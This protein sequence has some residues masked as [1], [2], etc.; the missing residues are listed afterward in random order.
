MATN[1]AASFSTPTADGTAGPF[2]IGFNYLE[3][4]EIDVT[5]DG[6][7]KTL[8][9]HYTFHSATQISFTS[10]NFPTS[11]Q[12]IRFQ[13]DT[14][15]SAK[16]VDFEDG[17]VLTEA[18]LDANSDQVLFG[19]QEFTDEINTNVVKKDG[20][21]AQ[22]TDAA[23]LAALTQPEVQIL[24]GA[25]VSTTELNTLDGV[26]STL[27]ASELNVLDGITASTA[28]LNQLTNKEVETSVTTNSN[29]KIP[30]SKAVNDLVVSVANALGGFV[31]IANATSFP[32]TNPDPSNNAG[33]VVSITDA[34]GL[35]IN[36]SGVATIANGAG[37]ST[38]TINGFPTDLR[39]K[40]LSNGIGLQVQTTTTLH[41]YTYH[42]SLVK[43]SD[44]IN[45][46]DDIN[47]FNNRYRV[48]ETT[49]TSNNDEG[50]LIFR[51]SDNKLLVFNGTIF[52]EASSIGNFHT[53]TL[54]SF[55]GTGGGSATF[56]G[57]AFK[58]NIDHP[59]E[60]AE[61]LLISINNVVQKPNSGTSQPSNG[62][63]LDGSTIILSAAP[64]A[65][66]DF[67][68]VTIGKS[69]N[70]GNVSDGTITNAKVASD[71]SIEGTKINPNFGN[72]NIFTSGNMNCSGGQFTISGSTP[73]MV[74]N[75]SEDNPDYRLVNS[76]G[77]FRIRDNTAGVNRITVHTDGHI[78]IT[79]R[80]DCLDALN[81]TGD[82]SVSGTV[83]GRDLASDGSKLDGIEANAINASNTAITNKLPLSGGT[84]TGIL[85][86]NRIAPLIKFNESDTSKLY[87][88]VLDGSALSIRKD[89]LAGSNIIQ[90]WNS[91]G[92]I[93]FLTN[94]DFASGIDVSGGDITGV[95]GSSVTGTTQ[96]AN[97]NS[98]KIAT[99][100]YVDNASAS[101]QELIRTSDSAV[102]VTAD[103]IV[104]VKIANQ[105][106]FHNG[107]F[108]TKYGQIGGNAQGI[109]IL[110]S[111][112][113][114]QLK[115]QTKGAT[116][117]SELTKIAIDD[118]VTI[119]DD[120]G[121]G[122]NPSISAKFIRDGAV[123]LHY[124]GSTTPKLATT[125]TGINV[126][127]DAT[128]TTGFAAGTTS[129][130]TAVRF[131]AF[132]DNTH[133]G[134]QI[135][136]EQD[137]EGDAVLGWT[138]T[139][140]RAWSAGIDNSDSNRWKLSSGSSVD[141]NTQI[142]IEQDGFVGLHHDSASTPKLQTTAT[143][144]TVDGR[145]GVGTDSASFP[146]HIFN[147]DTGTNNQVRIEQDGTGD[148]VLG[149]ALTGVRA[150]SLGID[151]TDSDKFKIS[152]A[153]N[154]HTN[155][156][157][158]IDGANQRV[159]IN[160]TSPNSAIDV[161]GMMRSYAASGGQ[162]TS[163][164]RFATPTETFD[165]F[166]GDGNANSQFNL[167]YGGSGGA[168]IVVTHDGIVK[169][170]NGGG[171]TPKLETSASGVKVN[172]NIGIGTATP[173]RSLHIVSN[174]T[175]KIALTDS[176]TTAEQNSLV[177]GIDFT[178]LD[179]STTTGTSA[180]IGAYHEDDQGNAY[181]RFDTGNASNVTE[182]MRITATGQVD[183]TESI[184]LPNSKRLYVGTNNDLEIYYD[185]VARVQADSRPM[186]LKGLDGSATQ[187]G[188]TMFKGGSAE[189]MFEAFN[190]GAVKL[191][192]DGGT[193]SNAKLKTT[194]YG[195]TVND[196][197]SGFTGTY[198]ARVAAVIEGSNSAG[199]VLNIMSPTSGYSG[200]F[201]GRPGSAT[202]GQIHYQ[203]NAITGVPADT[204]RFITVGGTETMLMNSTSID[205]KRTV[206][207]TSS[208][209]INI[210]TAGYAFLNFETDRTDT[211]Q[212]IGGPIFLANGSTKS[213]IQSLVSG[214]INIIAGAG[215]TKMLS[216]VPQGAVNL[217]YDA[218]TYSTAK[219]STT[220]TGVDVNG[221]LEI[222]SAGGLSTSPSLYVN[223]SS[224]RSFIHTF[225][226]LTPNMIGTQ[227]NILVLGRARSTKNA[228]F[229]AYKYSGT[230]GSNDNLFTISHWGADDLLT[231]N[232][233]G[234]TT[235]TG[236]L[237]VDTDTLFVDSTNDKVGI[238]NASPAS[239][240]DITG[241]VV[242][243]GDGT[244]DDIRI[245]EW[246]AATAFAG[247]FHKN[248]TGQEY[249]MISNDGS[250][251]I[252]STT[253]N[254]VYIRGG[255]NSTTN[256]IQ[257]SPAG[258]I[259]ITAANNVNI[260]DGNIDFGSNADNNPVISMKGDNNRVK[261]RVF[262]NTDF[263][264]GFS[265]NITHGGL[266]G[267]CMTFQVSDTANRGWLFLD[268]GHGLNQGAMA[269]TSEGKM[270]VAHSLRLGYG[271]SDTTESGATHALD[272]NGS[273]I[274]QSGN[275]IFATA[276]HGAD[277]LNGSVGT[278]GI[279]ELA[280]G[281]NDAANNLALV[282]FKY[283]GT[284]G[285]TSNKVFL[286]LDGNRE[287]ITATSLSITLARNTTVNGTLTETSDIA[288]KEN[289]QP[290]S[291]VL[292]KVKQL[293]GY[294]YN[295]K[296][297][298][299]ASMGVIAQDVEKV[300]PELVHGEEGK[301]SLQYS[302][303]VGALVEAVKELS[304]KVAALE[305][306]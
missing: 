54:S 183:F 129:L 209:G 247:V 188:I 51:K 163:G 181:L 280:I 266:N 110:N 155:T 50:D 271:E 55:N 202:R 58:F 77:Q 223:N 10:G 125:S 208:N 73:A 82:I 193:Y 105:A 114:T 304:A 109:A 113:G 53:N 84:L 224:S 275:K 116:G 220:A 5:V 159:G 249:M 211:T 141:S 88:L 11:G 228:A 40:T 152:S 234:N 197:D 106:S 300:F 30:T 230:A 153:T 302:G 48:V 285:S 46:S 185:G 178:T 21:L 191:Y 273:L 252:S 26:N 65:G 250:T 95:L 89:T 200:I 3:Q 71:A 35:V 286:G 75:D 298:E 131:H 18:D 239:A 119:F 142:T 102:R 124:G 164:L 154:L 171:T 150:Y 254:H 83:D 175:S 222:A 107:T 37:S 235:I 140:T 43:E 198:N 165:M 190:D 143:G 161:T 52:Q 151:N 24:D 136:I 282:G 219:L 229:L 169:L 210:D 174:G 245:G 284:S 238:N 231:I 218:G 170:F 120:G 296:D 12:T 173:N 39:S 291:N 57:S 74:F 233:Q 167:T 267:F 31:A 236:N 134:H 85:E 290:L 221:E 80:L 70:I 288:L 62:F 126:T 44:L 281:R 60:L 246:S 293:T 289:I 123:N 42:K 64:A 237:A 8:G 63:A 90:K 2:N 66:T 301:K 272:V 14:N 168:D 19:L 117:T 243:T 157:F 187:A 81:V 264:T 38:V 240:L 177:G 279:V 101:G 215:T 56:N 67:F 103:T 32:T 207:A 23:A 16:K 86:L 182:R 257:V 132:S 7:L 128:S 295:F 263:G 261:Y 162:G 203:H 104:G 216:A 15:I 59:P 186:Y 41:T 253:N 130:G 79:N 166:F 149:F 76:N 94:C 121:T 297:N 199:T 139:G 242:A 225:Q 6:V 303:L 268:S 232:G 196:G 144:V 160:N 72:Q 299:K 13:R 115:L 274:V 17:S 99:T 260:L 138:L 69:V 262:T 27:T 226:G 277:I 137:G 98:T 259:N 61:Q 133:V 4:S 278:N 227:K 206:N 22:I 36:S 47:D 97:D 179:Q 212:N 33:T 127:G 176:D 205:L 87:Y 248:Q 195:I 251:F 269:L 25:T 214:Q 147:D 180:H 255:G 29:T 108:T 276:D 135:I 145:I 287:L 28:N 91:D 217:F 111:V 294:K 256:E 118:N 96:S 34:G 244:F 9:T 49:P 283:S 20:G 148:A 93:D 100:A 306:K 258:G 158:T 45:L 265:G 213:K 78:D 1:T 68:I 292:D 194:S 192:F 156:L 172:G 305:A 146:V 92:H 201:F 241:D 122:S 189:K 184:S 270:N 112:N 204:F